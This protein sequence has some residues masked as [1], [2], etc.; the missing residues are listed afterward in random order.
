MLKQAFQAWR[1]ELNNILHGIG[2]FGIYSYPGAYVKSAQGKV[3]CI[4]LI[5][6]DNMLMAS[7]SMV[8]IKRFKTEMALHFKIKDLNDYQQTLGTV[9]EDACVNE[10]F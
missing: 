6:V 10:E 3:V 5:Y 7:E 4:L 8:E 2:Y 9:V 1:E